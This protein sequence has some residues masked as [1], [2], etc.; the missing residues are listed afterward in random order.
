MKKE[1]HLILWRTPF[2]DKMP[3]FYFCH[4]SKGIAITRDF[5]K[6]KAEDCIKFYN[7]K[8]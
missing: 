5:L 2:F 7:T 3:F 1:R 8:E 6:Q 4:F